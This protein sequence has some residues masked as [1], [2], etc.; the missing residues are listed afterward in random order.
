MR[1][2]LVIAGGVLRWGLYALLLAALCAWIFL[3]I[4]TWQA[5]ERETQILEKSLPAGGRYVKAGDIQVYIQDTGTLKGED[6]VIVP[7][8]GGWSGV[9]QPTAKALADAGFRVITLDLPPFGFSQRPKL[10]H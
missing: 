7:G 9:W 1:L 3:R 2:L 10:P 8:F 4:F 6:V 5:E